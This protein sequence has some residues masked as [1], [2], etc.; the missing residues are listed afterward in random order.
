MST[1]YMQRL[2]K[3]L[4]TEGATTE[5]LPWDLPDTLRDGDDDEPRNIDAEVEQ[6]K[7]LEQR[8]LAIDWTR[9]RYRVPPG[10]PKPGTTKQDLVNG[11]GR[12]RPKLIQALKRF[13]HYM[14]NA[15]PGSIYGP[16]NKSLVDMVNFANPP[17][18]I[19]DKKVLNRT[20]EY[21]TLPITN[22]EDGKLKEVGYEIGLRY[23]HIF[24]SSDYDPQY[25]P[26]RTVR[27]DERICVYA[28]LKN[29]NVLCHQWG[30]L[31]LSASLQDAL[32]DVLD[33][34]TGF[35]ILDDADINDYMYP[36]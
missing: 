7:Q 15:K 19:L 18:T 1:E 9:L 22:M 14:A 30:A 10:P 17:M 6:H 3:L 26:N 28:L 16:L 8:A 33:K 23:S 20:Y 5:E 34:F 25:R 24:G 12:P 21:L 13:D 4:E 36:K 2:I 29:L 32:A 27:F 31:P 11:P 35:G